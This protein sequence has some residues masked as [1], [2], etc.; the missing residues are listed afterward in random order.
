M[1]TD[2][3]IG[4]PDSLTV[5]AIAVVAHALS[6]FIHEAL[7]HGGACVA[8]GCTPRLLTTMQF[9]GD[10]SSLSKVAVAAISAGGSVANLVAAAIAML[11]LRRHRGPAGSGWFFLWLF[12]T[13]NLLAAAGYPLYSGVANIGDW[14]N[15]VQV[16][17]L[18][19]SGTCSSEASARSAIGLPPAGLLAAWAGAYGA[20]APAFAPPTRTRS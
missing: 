11:L 18:P 15:I 3:T 8:V 17:S 19:G 16:S 13:V 1:D 7:G 10:E 12:A 4:K 20:P 14:A 6:V 2:K 5:S 9:Q